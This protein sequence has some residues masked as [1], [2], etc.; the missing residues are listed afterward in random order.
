MNF[1]KILCL[2]LATLMLSCSGTAVLADST[3]SEDGA[4]AQLLATSTVTSDGVVYEYDSAAQTA[5]AKSLAS[6][7][8]TTVKIAA[9]ANS[10][11]VV[12]IADNFCTG[13]TTVTTVNLADATNLK[14]I[15]DNA[16]AYCTN[17]KTV[18]FKTSGSVL[19]EI[20]NNA[21]YYCP[22]LNTVSG[23]DNQTN[24][25]K[26][27]SCVFA[28]TPFMA[29]K[30]DEFVMLANVLVKY[31]GS[32]AIVTV[33]ETTTAIADAFFGKS[34]TSIDLGSV[35]YIGNNAFYGCRSLGE[36]SIP[37]AC[38]EIG[39]MAFAGCSALAK[40][41]YA[42]GLKKIGFNAFANCTSLASFEN[43]AET[44]SVLSYVGECAFWNCEKLGLLE[45]GNIETVNVG[46]FWNCFS[47]STDALSYYRV[48]T[49]VKAIGEGG[50]GNLSF[51]YI[52]VPETVESIA[53]SAFGNADGATYVTVKGSAADTYFASSNY[54]SVNYG[55]V[56]LDGKIAAD[57][58]LTIEE[59]IAGGA[60][61]NMTSDIGDAPALV[62]DSDNNS[63]ITLYDLFKIFS[64]IKE[65]YE[66]EKAA[67]Q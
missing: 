38:T 9:T 12:A 20:G 23:I 22:A 50:Y 58:I 19:S 18:S 8:A 24:L 66:A 42:G 26:V 49:S 33:P 61:E 59:H 25:S 35:E 4:Q 64:S 27:G 41:T 45:L 47:G 30:N 40:V 37:E 67:Q 56:N 17:L 51:T 57:D 13:N 31:N 32:S 63:K 55:D 60:T 7:T 54:K 2:G 14:S 3:S 44:A 46:S 16:F 6:T 34:I 21:F 10:Y 43:S 65:A 1:K 48:P 52:T 29:A 62:T 53:S 28:L 39:D 15:G 36:V 5:V 11:P